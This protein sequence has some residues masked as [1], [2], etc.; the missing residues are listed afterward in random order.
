[1]NKVNKFLEII[2]INIV[3]MF[4]LFLLVVTHKK[5]LKHYNQDLPL[6]KLNRFTKNIL[7]ELYTKLFK[8][9]ILILRQKQ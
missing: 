9:K 4:T 6:L 2:L 8:L 5:S 1:M 7:N 3:I